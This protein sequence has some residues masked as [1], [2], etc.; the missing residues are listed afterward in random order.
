MVVA[1]PNLPSRS[2]STAWKSHKYNRSKGQ[3][4]KVKAAKAPEGR[5]YKSHNICNHAPE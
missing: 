1:K 4:S 5:N 2:T 3:T